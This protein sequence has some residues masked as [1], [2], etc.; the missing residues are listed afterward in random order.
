MRDNFPQT[1]N[2]QNYSAKAFL[3]DEFSLALI[4]GIYAVNPVS[5]DRDIIVIK[6]SS[7]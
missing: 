2:L 6:D 4:T 7:R 3:A 5:D 1:E